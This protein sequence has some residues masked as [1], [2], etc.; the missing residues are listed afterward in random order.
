MRHRGFIIGVFLARILT[1]FVHQLCR[2]RMDVELLCC[3]F[4]SY[5]FYEVI[6]KIWY[7]CENLHYFQDVW[8]KFEEI[9]MFVITVQNLMSLQNCKLG[10]FNPSPYRSFESHSNGKKWYQMLTIALHASDFF[11]TL[12]CIN[13][14][15][16]SFYFKEKCTHYAKST[17]GRT[18]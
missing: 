9:L 17:S 10:L 14:I 16:I 18:L 4:H 3:A 13:V 6:L 7:W 5:N 1:A 15:W 8:L 2:R 12:L 11:P